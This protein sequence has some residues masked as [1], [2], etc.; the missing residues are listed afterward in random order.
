MLQE[1]LT[2]LL[3]AVGIVAALGLWAGSVVYVYWDTT[4]RQ[5]AGRG[6]TAWVLTAQTMRASGK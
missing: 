1:S 5:M 2:I 3:R 6:Q 4:Q